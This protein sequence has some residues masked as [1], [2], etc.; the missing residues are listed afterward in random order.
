VKYGASSPAGKSGDFPRQRVS[1]KDAIE[2]PRPVN[3][4]LPRVSSVHF[5]I[6]YATECSQTDMLSPNYAALPETILTST[7]LEIRRVVLL[8]DVLQVRVLAEVRTLLTFVDV[9]GRTQQHPPSTGRTRLKLMS[10]P[11]CR[12]IYHPSL[13][14]EYSHH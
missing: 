3:C 2:L 7:E 14:P 4:S 13:Q 10:L 5:R 8:N 6:T 11:V 12:P 9:T 1:K